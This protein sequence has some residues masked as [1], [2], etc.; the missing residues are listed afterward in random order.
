[1]KYI[2]KKP[3]EGIDWKVGEIKEVHLQE[4]LNQFFA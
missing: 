4:K 2:L 1:M 3:I